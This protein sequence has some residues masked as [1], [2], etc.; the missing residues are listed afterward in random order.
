MVNKEFR[1]KKQ[2]A[3]IVDNTNLFLSS[4]SGFSFSFVES[5]VSSFCTFVPGAALV[6]PESDLFLSLDSDL[7]L[8]DGLVDFLL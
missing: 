1:T 6:L 4:F 8:D 2:T 7:D 5:N 3:C